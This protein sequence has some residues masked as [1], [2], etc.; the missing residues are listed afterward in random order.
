MNKI[1][2]IPH[3]SK[4]I[5]EEYLDD[6]LVT[7][8]YLNLSNDI[9]CD[10]DLDKMVKKFNPNSII[11]PYSRLFCD[12]ERFDSDDEVMNN[13]GMGVLYTHNHDLVKIRENPNPEIKKYYYEHHKAFNKKVKKM[14]EE[15]ENVVIIDLHSYSKYALPYELNKSL[16][17]PEICIG[18]NKNY[19]KDLLNNIINLANN[20]NFKTSINKPFSGSIIPSEFVDDKRVSSL[21]LEIRKDLYSTKE[22]FLKVSNFLKI[23]Y[24]DI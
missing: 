1:F 10:N 21:M 24:N 7:R 22:G 14:L 20:F 18:L 12:V 17:R 23:I 9:I 15:N 8:E 13:I 19:N 5:P 3:S 11:F 16:D 2:H 4:Y 6:Y